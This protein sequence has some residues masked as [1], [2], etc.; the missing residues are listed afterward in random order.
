MARLKTHKVGFRTK[1]LTD[2]QAA[3]MF[4]LI[5]CVAYSF[6]KDCDL[7]SNVP[8]S[9]LRKQYPDETW[10]RGTRQERIDLVS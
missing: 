4:Y 3:Q 8:L 10:S 6:D 9:V 1:G 2:E 5:T 7:V